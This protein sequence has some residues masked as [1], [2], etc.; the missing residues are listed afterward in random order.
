MC[1][2]LCSAEGGVWC[3]ITS[4]SGP[5]LTHK[6][7]LTFIVKCKLLFQSFFFSLKFPFTTRVHVKNTACLMPC[8]S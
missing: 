2:V 7:F 8:C 3:G 4:K 5:K 1:A 6:M